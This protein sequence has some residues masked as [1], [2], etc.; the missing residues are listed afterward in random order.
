MIMKRHSTRG[1]LIV[2]VMLLC[3]MMSCVSVFGASSAVKLTKSNAPTTITQGSKF[4]IKGTIKAKKKIKRVEI[5]VTTAG[6][7]KWTSLKYDNK[8]VNSKTFKIK[9]AA[10]KIKFQKLKAG[11]YIYRI[12]VHTSDKKVRCVM[13]Q[14]FTVT[15]PAPAAAPSA[16]T[17]TT[18]TSTSAAADKVT[19]SGVN[20]PTNYP[21]GKV[22][23]TMGTV[24]CNNTI[25]RIEAGIVVA[26][27]NKW[28]EYKYDANVN[29]ESFDLKKVDSALMFSKLPGGDFYYRIYVHTANGVTIALNKKFTVTPS[30]KPLAAINWAT[31]IANDSRFTYGKGYGGYFTCPVCAGKFGSSQAQYT[32]MPFLA[33]AFAHGSGESSLLG[34]GRHVMNLNDDNFKG[35]LGNYWFKVGLC[36]DLDIKD[37][38]PGDVIIKWSASNDSGHSWMYGGG[39][40]IIE[41]VPADIRVLSTGAA[42]KLKRYG[43]SEGTPSKNYVMRFRK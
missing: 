22:F 43:S 27:T 3:L 31:N 15:E 14:T 8:K 17:T 29:S 16:T 42:T 10:S 25:K 39:D 41:A 23:N 38:Q 18:A 34:S 12:Y 33:A 13:N 26:A 5:G 6:G 19:L 20:F 37:L 40:T 32:C 4:T 35:T 9:K 1:R 7:G 36:R 21:V 11:T 30:T 28:S 24:S 2:P